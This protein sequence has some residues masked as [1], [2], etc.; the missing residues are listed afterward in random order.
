MTG[1]STLLR[2]VRDATFRPIES[3]IQFRSALGMTSVSITRRKKIGFLQKIISDN[4][5]EYERI[6]EYTL[7]CVVFERLYS[8]R[9]LT[10][11]CH[12]SD[13]GLYRFLLNL[14]HGSSRDRRETEVIL[15]AFVA[16]ASFHDCFVQV[17][18]SF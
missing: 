11:R 2:L 4:S 1:S 3:E 13:L 6:S 9:N 14:F 12:D 18:V 17:F 15:C 10:L 7:L 5:I 16:T 8:V